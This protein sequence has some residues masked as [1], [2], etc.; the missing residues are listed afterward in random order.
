MA[1]PLIISHPFPF[2]EVG[3]A[4]SFRSES[5]KAMLRTADLIDITGWPRA[6]Y[7][8]ILADPPW[9]FS[10][11]S[12]AGDGRNANRHY[13]C[14]TLE[15]IRALPVARLARRDAVLFL[16]ITG[17]LLPR[18]LE[19]MAAWGFEFKTVAFTWVKRTA[20]GRS[21]HTGTGFWMRANAEM[22][23]LGV[24]GA[25]KRLARDVR[26]LII[27]PVREHSRKTG[28]AGS[29]L[30]EARRGKNIRHLVEGLLLIDGLR[31][32]AAPT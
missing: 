29:I 24:R 10:S 11:R 9:P 22:C 3:A 7:G 1:R 28:M 4:A 27:A 2:W 30:T 32:K 20:T 12:P 18:G 15:A 6:R 8:A 25:L 14:V 5:R 13:E 19:V 17:P 21:F 23:I 16:W 26:Q 31:P